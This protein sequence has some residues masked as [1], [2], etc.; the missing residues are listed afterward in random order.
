MEL[1]E[2][3]IALIRLLQD[4]ER[5]MDQG[6]VETVCYSDDPTIR[7]RRTEKPLHDGQP[8]TAGEI[9]S[10]SKR[11]PRRAT[12]AERAELRA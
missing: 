2:T 5:L 11:A 7:Y 10:Q 9:R 3:D 6:L 1:S 12:L 8:V 4:L